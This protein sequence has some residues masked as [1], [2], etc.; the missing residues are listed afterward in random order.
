MKVILNKS[1][2]R[3]LMMDAMVSGPMPDAALIGNA[4]CQHE[5]DPHRQSGFVGTMSPKAMRTSG[6]ANTGDRPQGKGKQQGILVTSG[7]IG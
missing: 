1:Y 3:V 7:N 5:E 6:D 2:L 4:C